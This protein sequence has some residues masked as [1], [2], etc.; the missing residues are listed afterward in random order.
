MLDW[1]TA[2]APRY[3]DISVPVE[4]VH[5]RE[6]TTVA[7]RIHA[8]PLSEAVPGANLTTLETPSHMPHHTHFD[9]V[10]DAIDRAAARAGLR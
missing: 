3:G 10:I 9:T 7:Y 5:G 6:D 4:I 1:V 2:Q 8:I